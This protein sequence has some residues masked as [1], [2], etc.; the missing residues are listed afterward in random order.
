MFFRE[1]VEILKRNPEHQCLENR[2]R[3]LQKTRLRSELA[4]PFA[5]F[6]SILNRG[7]GIWMAKGK[8]RPLLNLL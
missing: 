3:S 5:D 8:D 1:P 4:V 2:Q 6:L 7:K